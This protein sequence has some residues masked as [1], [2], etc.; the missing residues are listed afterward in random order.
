LKSPEFVIIREGVEKIERS[1]N[2]YV[3]MDVDG[4][5]IANRRIS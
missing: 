5:R 1:L 2:E 3:P 4:R